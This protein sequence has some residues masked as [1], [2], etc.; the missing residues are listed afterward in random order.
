LQ[1]LAEQS[2]SRQPAE[3]AVEFFDSVSSGE[4]SA[5]FAALRAAGLATLSG[6]EDCGSVLLTAAYDSFQ[7]LDSQDE[8]AVRE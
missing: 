3:N 5:E 8:A 7:Y 4:G 2:N 1:S 6:C